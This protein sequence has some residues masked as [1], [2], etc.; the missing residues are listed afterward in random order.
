LASLK[1]AGDD[2]ILLL[3]LYLNNAYL[4]MLPLF[5]LTTAEQFPLT[6]NF[7]LLFSLPPHILILF[8]II[9][10]L[11]PFFILDFSSPSPSAAVLCNNR[12]IFI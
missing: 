9:F 5:N 3:Q 10:L 1:A 2:V 7:L 4:K 8:L 11:F 6:W 12:S